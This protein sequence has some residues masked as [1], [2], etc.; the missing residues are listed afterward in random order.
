MELRSITYRRFIWKS[1]SVSFDSMN[2]RTIFLY[3]ALSVDFIRM[4]E[5]DNTLHKV[6]INNLFCRERNRYL[7]ICFNDANRSINIQ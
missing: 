5:N 6:A 3:S 2:A 1:T 7:N 4:T